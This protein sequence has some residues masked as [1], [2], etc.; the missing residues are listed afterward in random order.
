V[1]SGPP[2]IEARV[3]A[4]LVLELAA[5]RELL[6]EQEARHTKAFTA[7]VNRLTKRGA[8]R[9]AEVNYNTPAEAYDAHVHAYERKLGQEIVDMLAKQVDRTVKT[10]ENI[11]NLVDAL[12]RNL[13]AVCTALARIENAQAN[14][15]TLLSH[16]V[17]RFPSY[18]FGGLKP[19]QTPYTCATN[20]TNTTNNVN[21]YAAPPSGDGVESF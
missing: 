6:K 12:N 15:R 4:P 9:E 11:I 20:T 18:D 7:I 3:L 1:L 13:A 5:L 16:L 2:P 8:E 19:I 17:T 10:D 21:P 14:G